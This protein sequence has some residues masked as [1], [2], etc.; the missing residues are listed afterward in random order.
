MPHLG[1][2][3]DLVAWQTRGS[4][5]CTHGGLVGIHRGGVDVPVAK[6]QRAFDHGLAIFIGHA[7]CAEPQ[8]GDGNT[9]RL[10]CVQHVRLLGLPDG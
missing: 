2:D 7:E 9:L 5:G 1:G 8:P 10:Q 3:E 6:R 4:D